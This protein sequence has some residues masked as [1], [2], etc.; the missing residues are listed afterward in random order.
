MLPF[1]QPK[2]MAG[3]IMAKVKPEGGVETTGEEGEMDHGFLAAAEA[4]ISAIHSKDA[5]AVAKA[6][7]E[8]FEIADAMP[9]EEG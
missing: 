2:K 7:H 1:L 3:I 6:L 8:A 9:H 4:L 5:G